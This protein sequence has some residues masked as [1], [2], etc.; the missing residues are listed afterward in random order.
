MIGEN[1]NKAIAELTA[2]KNFAVT[3]IKDLT[4]KLINA[5]SE[6]KA[7]QKA[8]T[9]NSSELTNDNIRLQQLTDQQTEMVK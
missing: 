7:L 4:T 5:E 6:V 3:E 8:Q 9:S 2:Y 1:Q